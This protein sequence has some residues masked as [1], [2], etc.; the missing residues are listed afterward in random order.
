M[1][2]LI[3]PAPVDAGIDDR[4]RLAMVV[5]MLNVDCDC[6]IVDPT[7][8]L[9]VHDAGPTP[10]GERDVARGEDRDRHLRA[11]SAAVPATRGCG[12]RLNRMRRFPARSGR[13]WGSRGDPD[14]R[15]R[16]GRSSW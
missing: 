11:L 12:A 7:G 2:T 6:H 16:E 14:R 13:R 3:D 1:L 9:L 5:D 15:W 10:G 8:Q 4:G